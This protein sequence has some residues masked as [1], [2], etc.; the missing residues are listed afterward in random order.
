MQQPARDPLCHV[1][2]VGGNSLAKE[3]HFIS[4]GG[5]G[6]LCEPTDGGKE[7]H[8]FKKKTRKSGEKKKSR[9]GKSSP[10]RD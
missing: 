6:V 3:T 5:K 8:M 4:E 9:A 7:A 1:L 2:L 10:K